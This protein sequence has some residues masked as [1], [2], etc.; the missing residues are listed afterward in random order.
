[1]S[2]RTTSARVGRGLRCC[3]P[4]LVLVLCAR[5]FFFFFFLSYLRTFSP[6]FI[7]RQSLPLLI[8]CP[9]FFFAQHWA[10]YSPF[11]ESAT[12]RST[13][14]PSFLSLSVYTYVAALISF[15]SPAAH[16]LHSIRYTAVSA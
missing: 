9:P 11:L 15:H 7:L 8:F 10:H 13:S 5:L 3:F 1:M 2:G 16:I 12:G 14:A 4:P 6:S